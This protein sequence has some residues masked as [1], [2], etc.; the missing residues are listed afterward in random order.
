MLLSI[1]R[2]NRLQAWIARAEEQE[3]KQSGLASG[4]ANSVVGNAFRK[5]FEDK[6]DERQAAVF[7][8]YLTSHEQLS[9]R[10]RQYAQRV[11]EKFSLQKVQMEGKILDDNSFWFL[12]EIQNG[13][14]ASD[15][16]VIL[17]RS[18][19]LDKYDVEKLK[20]QEFLDCPSQV[21]DLFLRE[22]KRDDKPWTE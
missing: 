3:L 5:R 1:T 12:T 10:E 18:F 16:I 21:E 6:I 22:L 2:L 8:A 7:L 4:L 19:G 11:C 15:D 20:A 14:V 9:D 17:A 13:S